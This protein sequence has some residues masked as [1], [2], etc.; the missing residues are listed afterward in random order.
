M[1]YGLAPGD[2]RQQCSLRRSGYNTARRQP[3]NSTRRRRSDPHR[4]PAP[5]ATSITAG[6]PTGYTDRP[7]YVSPQHTGL[8]VWP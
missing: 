2:G 1:V 7:S 5:F 3:D 6:N 8:P 4:N